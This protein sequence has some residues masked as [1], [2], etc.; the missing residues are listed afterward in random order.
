MIFFVV[1]VS[2]IV[3]DEELENGIWMDIAVQVIVFAV[4]FA[5]EEEE[6]VVELEIFA[7]SILIVIF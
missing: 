3:V 1:Q 5:V 7:D 2:E 4:F 6:V